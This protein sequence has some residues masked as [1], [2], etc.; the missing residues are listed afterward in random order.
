MHGVQLFYN[1]S[2]LAKNTQRIGLLSGFA[3]LPIA[4]R[5]AAA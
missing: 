2:G 1:L 4:E 3:N 5:Y